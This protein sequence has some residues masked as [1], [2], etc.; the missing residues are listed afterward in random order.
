MNNMN[1]ISTL[2]LIFFSL[3]LFLPKQTLSG[4]ITNAQVTG[5]TTVCNGGTTVLTLTTSL[6]GAGGAGTITYQWEQSTTNAGGS[7]SNASGGSGAT[8]SA[9]TSP[10]LASNIYYRCKVTMTGSSPCASVGTNFTNGTYYINATSVTL[11]TASTSVSNGGVLI[12]V[13]QVPNAPSPAIA[14]SISCTSF[15]A[16]W[17]APGSGDTPTNYFLDVSTSSIFTSFVLNNQSVGNVLTYSVTGL[18]VGTTYYYRVR[19]ADCAGSGSSSSNGTATTVTPSNAGCYC[20]ASGPGTDYLTNVTFAGINN[21][22]GYANYT[23][24]SSPTAT[25]NTG[26]T[27]QISLTESSFADYYAVW[28]DYNDDG[29]FAA[30]ESVFNGQFANSAA[31]VTATGSITIPGGATVGTTRM[32]VIHSYSSIATTAACTNPATYG[33]VEDY[34]VVISGPPATPSTPTALAGTL[35]SCNSF[36]ANWNSVSGATSYVIDVSTVNNFA[37]FVAGYNGLNVGNVTTYNVTGL[38]ALTTY[39]YRIRASNCAGSSSSSSNVISIATTSACYC[40][41]AGG[42]AS[43]TYYIS[44]FN[45][46][47]INNTS[48][49]TGYTFYS[50]VTAASA[51]TGCSYSYTVTGSS[52]TFGDYVGIWIDFN[53]NGSFADAGEFVT[54]GSGTIGNGP[55]TNTGNITIPANASVGATRMRVMIRFGGGAYTSASSCDV[56]N[57]EAEDYVINITSASTSSVNWTGTTNTDWATSSNWSNGTIPSSC[58]SVIIPSGGNQPTIAAATAASCYSLTINSGATL[59]VNSTTGNLTVS[60]DLINNG[61]LNFTASYTPVSGPS[62]AALANSIILNG[63]GNNWGGTGTYSLN[64]IF[65]IVSGATYTMTG[66]ARASRLDIDYAS[67]GSYGTLSLGS[68]T[69]SVLDINQNGYINLNTGTLQIESLA[70]YTPYY[71]TDA[72]F[73]ENTGTIYFNAGTLWTAGFQVTGQTNF[74]F[75]NMKVNSQNSSGFH[76][77]RNDVSTLTCTNNFEVSSSNSGFCHI[78]INSSLTVGGNLLI[79][80]G[81][82]LDCFDVDGPSSLPISVAGNWTNNGTFLQNAGTVTLNGSGDQYIG[83]TTSTT[84]YNLTLN[85]PGGI[86]YLST[87]T[88]VGQGLAYSLGFYAVYDGTLALGSGKLNLNKLKL[89]IINSSTSTAITRTSGYIISEDGAVAYTTAGIKHANNASVLSM[90]IDNITGSHV[91][92]FATTTGVYIPFTFKLNAGVT[93][94]F[95]YVDLATFESGMASRSPN[96]IM[97]YPPA[98][99]DVADY[100][101]TGV[102]NSANTVKRF[103]QITKGGAGTGNA[104]ITFTY[105]ETAENPDNGEGAGATGMVAQ[106]WNGTKWSAPLASQTFTIGNGSSTSTVQVPGVSTF[107]PWAIAKGISPLPIELINFNVKK[108]KDNGADITWETLTEKNNDYFEVERSIDGETFNTIGHV[109]GAGNSTAQ[110]LYSLVD[111]SPI[112]GVNYYRL[113]QIDNDNTSTYSKI[114]SVDFSDLKLIE[115]NKNSITINPNPIKDITEIN[116]NSEADKQVLVQVYDAQAK[117]I[118]T[119]TFTTVAG[120]NKFPIDLSGVSAGLFM[121]NINKL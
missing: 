31:P 1:R 60:G 23:F 9:Y 64:S 19:A 8:T 91:Y 43:T 97:P 78:D 95:G 24:Y 111:K 16:N 68:N 79:N 118:L 93:G 21:S 66:N 83:G 39:Y 18:T 106:R 12:T 22:T 71:L 33:E 30:S 40:T 36:I 44:N 55:Y 20:T 59:T 87:N 103:W 6:C 52:G 4:T 48:A 115:F 113:K 81:G 90:N 41:P 85:K 38:S 108:N 117:I 57:D 107:S 119:K 105:D 53:Q 14:T 61:T 69:L 37:S 112:I 72:R 74:T 121:K 49:Y 25:V 7:W 32:R 70:N 29:V 65:R 62:P 98:V 11:A 82:V 114:V 94:S 51:N 73:N 10:A 84:F 86:V 92:P 45:F 3:V 102:D 13:K 26:C 17:I 2:L 28:I 109:K 56:N 42:Y 54:T 47:G 5:T 63:T 67:A 110:L 96:Y 89:T 27:Y 58:V 75:Y 76:I 80:S 15:S 100:T 88:S 34:L 77:G 101:Y 35:P 120:I 116:L 104:D 99:L 50:S 46:A